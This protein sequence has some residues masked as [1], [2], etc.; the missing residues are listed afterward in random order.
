M[1]VFDKENWDVSHIF[2]AYLAFLG[3]STKVAISLNIPAEVVDV[4]AEKENW[5]AKLKTYVALRSPERMSRTDRALRLAATHIQTH[6]LLELLDRLITHLSDIVDEAELLEDLSVY[7]GT[8][9]KLKFSV[10][11]L[12]DV[13]RAHALVSRAANRS[14]GTKGEQEKDPGLT[15]MDHL[16]IQEAMSRAM[17]AADALPGVDS[18][19]LVKQSLDKWRKDEPAS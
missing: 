16:E 12:M 6:M 17:K 9:K 18:V 19:A 7:C 13:C 3:N 8:G 2:L 11:A 14:V 4:L 5:A 1:T 10:K 15:W